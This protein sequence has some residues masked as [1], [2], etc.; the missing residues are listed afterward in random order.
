MKKVKSNNYNLTVDEELESE[1]R[2]P[3]ERLHI[4]ELNYLCCKYTYDCYIQGYILR[5]G[6]LIIVIMV[7]RG[8]E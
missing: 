5:D 1:V 4:F 3:D 8:K 6:E 2:F 7:E